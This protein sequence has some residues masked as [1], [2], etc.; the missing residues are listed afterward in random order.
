MVPVHLHWFI[1]LFSQFL[2]IGITNL[3]RVLHWQLF[4][5]L[6]LGTL[7]VWQCASAPLFFLSSW[8]GGIRPKLLFEPDCEFVYFYCKFRYFYWWVNGHR[9]AF[10]PSLSRPVEEWQLNLLSG[11]GT[12]EPGTGWGAEDVVEQNL[13]KTIN[14]FLHIFKP[15]KTKEMGSTGTGV[16]WTGSLSGGHIQP[17]ANVHSS[18]TEDVSQW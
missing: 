4:C 3:K 13:V 11:L 17:P 1:S 14:S 9:L 18:R 5:G 15:S 2:T 6:S 7:I 10:G 12:R 8:Q 16:W